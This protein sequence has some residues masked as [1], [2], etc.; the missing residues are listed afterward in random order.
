M[1]GGRVSGPA[2]AWSG[3]RADRNARRQGFGPGT[4]IRPC[5]VQ[6]DHIVRG[7]FVDVLV[8]AR[9][10]PHE[11]TAGPSLEYLHMRAAVLT[12]SPYRQ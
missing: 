10:A 6:L 2:A 9:N 11:R 1:K 4:C 3:R 7:S 12:V 5:D 8:A